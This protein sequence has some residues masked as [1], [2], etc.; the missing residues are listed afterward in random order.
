[1]YSHQKLLGQHDGDY[2]QQIADFSLVTVFFA[3]YYDFYHAQ[4]HHLTVLLKKKRKYYTSIRNLLLSSQFIS[5]T[6]RSYLTGVKSSKLLSWLTKFT[7]FGISI[8]HKIFIN[9]I[10]IAKIKTTVKVKW[11]FHNKIK[12]VFTNLP[13][14]QH[15]LATTV[16]GVSYDFITSEIILISS[17]GLS[18]ERTKPIYRFKK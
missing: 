14:L 8:L 4:R 18:I 10:F 7:I 17:F 6:T 2:C 16:V 15:T 13:E 12:A 5:T 1:M 9:V 3:W 11:I